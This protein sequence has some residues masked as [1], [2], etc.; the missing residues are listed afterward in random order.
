MFGHIEF[1]AQAAPGRGIISSMVLISEDLDEID[2]EWVGSDTVQFQTNYFS[3][4]DTSTYDRGGF[5]AVETPQQQFHKYTIDWTKD[6]VTWGVDGTIVRTLVNNGD[7]YYPQSPMQVRFGSWAG[8]DPGNAPGT[9][10]WAGGPTDYTQGPYN[11]YVK[12]IS[13]QDYST[14]KEYAYTDHS[15]TW[16]SIQAV[17][18]EISGDPKFT[19]NYTDTSKNDNQGSNQ[20][21][22]NSNNSNGPSV[23]WVDENSNPPSTAPVDSFQLPTLTFVSPSNVPSSVTVPTPPITTVY[24]YDGNTGF[25][26]STVW[27]SSIGSNINSD[28]GDGVPKDNS[29][30]MTFQF[31]EGSFSKRKRQHN[32][33]EFSAVA[34]PTSPGNNYRV[35]GSIG[36]ARN[37]Q[38]KSND[39]SVA[40]NAASKANICL[41][42]STAGIAVLLYTVFGSL[43][44]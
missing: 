41:L 36:N 17:D 9:I 5:H 31:D 7:N 11:F 21:G 18:G 22:N 15:G 33:Q 6:S 2:I 8:G 23:V 25:V 44:F 39:N 16:T 30:A 3:K 35:G 14:G 37:V 12:T 4:G 13:V 32:S 27:D 19:S 1:E 10:E 43:V 34:T 38:G 24:T 40:A 42:S 29:G 20:S 28:F 26:I